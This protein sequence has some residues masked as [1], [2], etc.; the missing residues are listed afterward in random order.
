MINPSCTIRGMRRAAVVWARCVLA[1]VTAASLFVVVAPR[2]H[3]Y[4]LMTCDEDNDGEDWTDSRGNVWVCTCPETEDFCFWAFYPA[5]LFTTVYTG[6]YLVTGITLGIRAEPGGRI[7][8]GTMAQAYNAMH[9]PWTGA[10]A[11]VS[12][13]ILQRWNG[14]FWTTCRDSGNAASPSGHPAQYSG[15]NQPL[16]CGSG[17]YRNT[18]SA[19]M[20]ID[21]RWW[22]GTRSTA[23]VWAVSPADDP[24]AA[25]EPPPP[26]ED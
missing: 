26:P 5:W 3:G 25:T 8:A 7:R 9:Q 21:G 13:T 12:R 24:T 19:W 20:V 4:P 6:P 14:L 23:A 17:W 11:I 10:D 18:G 2:A 16:P 15:F 22:G 1:M